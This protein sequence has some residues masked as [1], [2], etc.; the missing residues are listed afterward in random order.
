MR[1]VI[2]RYFCLALVALAVACVPNDDSS[3]AQNTQATTGV[4]PV[5]KPPPRPRRANPRMPALPAATA[6]AVARPAAPSGSVSAGPAVSAAPSAS[7]PAM[8]ARSPAPDAL[9][10]ERFVDTFD[11]PALGADY[12]ATSPVWRIQGGRLCGQGA[13]NHPVWLRRKLPKNARIEFDASSASPD[14]DIKVEVW[15]DGHSFA[16]TTSYTNAS[17]YVVIF[18]GWKNQFH[19]L[20]R[21]DEHAKDRPEVKITPGGDL[22]A[23][24]VEPNRS[25][26]F[27]VER[28]DGKTIRWLVDDIEIISF[29]DAAPLA[30]AGHE[31][32]GFNDWD[33][34]VCFDNLQI[35]PL[36]GS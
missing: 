32:M 27:K 13:K 33:V 17:S 6:S 22:K 29:S 8:A 30:G 7:A 4:P 34:P 28:D 15:G 12:T 11:R 23:R 16:Q 24:P 9:I 10:T 25:Y 3:K 31:H 36:G 21:I 14:G 35:T 18:G 26:H 19:V 20:A 5:R 1:P 2:G